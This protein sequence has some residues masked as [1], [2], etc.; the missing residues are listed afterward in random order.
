MKLG[1]SSSRGG[2]TGIRR[3]GKGGRFDQNILYP[4]PMSKTLKQLKYSIK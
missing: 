4:G 1:G 3:E 2:K